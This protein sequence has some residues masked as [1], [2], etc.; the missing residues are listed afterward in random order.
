MKLIA[1]A[2]CAFLPIVVVGCGGNASATSQGTVVAI[3][4]LD[5]NGDNRVNSADAADVAK[6]ADL[7]HDGKHDLFDAAFL[8]GID[9]PLDPKRDRSE[10]KHVSGKAPE[11]MVADG[12]IDPASITCDNSA[13]PI[14]VV[15]VGGGV[16][17]V[18]KS[19]D[20]AGVRSIV[21]G[22]LKQYKDRGTPAMAIIAG[23][24]VVAATSPNTAMEQWMTHAV[25]TWLDHFPCMRAVTLGHSWGAVTAD[26]VTARLER[27]YAPR[28]IEDIDIDR[29]TDLYTGDTQ[30]RPTR[31]HV[32]NIYESNSGVLNGSP[33]NSSNVENWDASNVQAPKNG[34]KGGPLTQV[35][36]TTIDN[37]AAVKQR[38][39]AEVGSRS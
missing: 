27:Q 34:D 35:I 13:K 16:V 37:S 36:H 17:D 14:L 25:Q 33:Y 6:L 5:M 23:P 24:A 18:E 28:I 2:A 26:V 20:A 1:L 38:I 15:G 4:C 11:Y 12:Y 31:V 8:N 39:V 19:G 32:F 9:I 21:D 22:L 7:T 10:C 29:T 30:S 3:E